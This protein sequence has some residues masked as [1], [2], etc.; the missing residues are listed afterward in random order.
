MHAEDLVV[1]D[2]GER[3]VVEHVGEVVP[4]IR[5]AVL[6]ATLGVEAVGLRHTTRFVVAADEMHAVRVA[7]FE[8]DE[9]GDRFDTE[10][11]AVDVV[12]CTETRGLGENLDQYRKRREEKRA[13][14]DARAGSRHT[15]K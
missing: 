2:D 15:K 5:V 13:C 7:Q 11:A 8:A 3:Q 10:E 9:K 1:D 6:A 14:V 12:A 4:H